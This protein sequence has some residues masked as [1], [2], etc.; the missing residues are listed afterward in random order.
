MNARWDTCVLF[1][2]LLFAQTNMTGE[3]QG[4]LAN[5]HLV[6]HLDE[7]GGTFTAVD[8]N[9]TIPMDV[10]TFNELAVH[11]EI[12]RAGATYDGKLSDDGSEIVG[13]WQQAGHAFPLTLH[14]PGA[15]AKTT[16]KPRTIGSVALTPCRTQD[17]NTEALC[18]KYEVFEDRQPQSGRKIAL[19]IMVLPA[20]TDKPA[21][22]PWVPLAG[23]PGQR[24]TELYPLLSATT[25]IRQQRDVILIDQRG[26]G[27]SNRLACVLRDPNDVQ[28]MIGD[29][30]SMEKIRACRDELSKQA[31][32]TQY[33][34]NNAADDLDDVRRAMGF[35]KI[36]LFGDSYGTRLALVYVRR[37]G[38]HVRTMALEAVAPPSY[39]LFVTFPKTIAASVQGVLDR[40]AANAPCH[41]AFPELQAEYSAIVERLGKS[42]AKTEL[43]SQPVTISLDAF[44]GNL[45]PMI[46]IPELASQVPYMIH[47][48]YQNDW[49]VFASG[50][51]LARTAIDQTVDRGLATSVL[52]A[53]DIPGASAAEVRQ[54]SFQYRLYADICKEWP[55]AAAE[56]KFYAPVR[57]KVPSLLIAGALDPAT[58]PE[59]AFEAARGLTNSRVVII[60][61]GSHATASPCIDGL[62]TTFLD[63]NKPLDT[64]CADQIHLPPFRG[65]QP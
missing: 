44:T 23:G 34:T 55:H 60:R 42:P 61:N 53:E 43:K 64:S 59:S 13:T 10:V 57:S 46:Y 27:G 65:A 36:D 24:A 30:V 9:V 15:V 39:R 33:T 63:Q 52:C 58:P 48:A 31:D 20:L 11:M 35:D 47:A 50:A 16:L 54:A 4:M 3:W 21:A 19:N 49:R 37:H 45:R 6:L 1:F 56:K 5:Q 40:C 62:I 28:A 12:K 14:R 18:G 7:K 26:T 51:L 22:N 17:G 38:E 41:K 8:Q 29:T 32:L 2:F 25:K